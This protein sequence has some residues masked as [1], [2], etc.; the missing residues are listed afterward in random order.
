MGHPLIH[1][2]RWPGR[3]PVLYT[4]QRLEDTDSVSSI[5]GGPRWYKME[6]ERRGLWGLA[7]ISHVHG[8]YRLCLLLIAIPTLARHVGDRAQLSW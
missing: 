6:R 8:I 7:V 1:F 4:E 2:T 3:A 5:S